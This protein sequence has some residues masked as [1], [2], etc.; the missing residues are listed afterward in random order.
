[1]TTINTVHMSKTNTVYGVDNNGRSFTQTVANADL[2]SYVAN[3]DTTN[4][5]FSFSVYSFFSDVQLAKEIAK[6]AKRVASLGLTVSEAQHP[7]IN[8]YTIEGK[9]EFRVL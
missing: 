5:V 2:A 1:M 3:A 8:G 6:F 7:V 9:M 4:T